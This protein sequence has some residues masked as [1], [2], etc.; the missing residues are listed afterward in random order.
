MNVDYQ[1]T[2]IAPC[3]INCGTC[4]AFFR[5]ERRCPGC[6]AP[7]EEGMGTHALTCRIKT[8][9]LHVDGP[10]CDTCRKFPCA[11]LRKLDLRYRTNYGESLVGNLRRLHATGMES[12]LAD[13][14]ARFTCA[15][16]GASLS[17]HRNDCPACGFPRNVSH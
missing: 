3:G 7:S 10:R 14:K 16:C 2:M 6:I 13:D 8:C 1:A 17:V 5:R 4:W 11:R 15:S 9:A 12:H